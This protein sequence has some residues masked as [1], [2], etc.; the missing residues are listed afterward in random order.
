MNHYEKT[1]LRFQ[2]TGCGRCCS[3]DPDYYVFLTPAEAEGIRRYLQLSERWFRRHYLRH[4]PRDELVVN[5]QGGGSCVFLD[6]DNRCRIYAAR[7]VQCRTY[8]FWPE[9][10]RSRTAWR[11]EAR[12]CEGIDRGQVVPLTRIRALLAMQRP[13]E[14][15]D[16]E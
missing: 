12:R 5:N 2:C 1:A 10:A 4:T 16:G 9:V 8:P 15:D 14:P 6:Q 11:R 7:P 13:E 3:G